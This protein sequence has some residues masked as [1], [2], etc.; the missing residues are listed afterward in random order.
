VIEKIS[1]GTLNLSGFK[2][3]QIVGKAS[4]KNA[5]VRQ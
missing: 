3:N 2:N 5:R 4:N 1:R